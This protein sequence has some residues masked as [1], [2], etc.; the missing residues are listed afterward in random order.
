MAHA[1]AYRENWSPETI[2]ALHPFVADFEEAAAEL[3]RREARLTALEQ[4]LTSIA[5][6][7]CCGCCQEAALVARAA[8]KG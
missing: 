2:N 7:S 8:L 3:D 5:N 6:G 1:K 4:A